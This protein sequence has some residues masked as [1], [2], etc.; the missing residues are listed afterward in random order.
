MK[1]LLRVILG[2]LLGL[3]IVLLLTLILPT[4]QGPDSGDTPRSGF[5]AEDASEQ[6]SP[7]QLE[8]QFLFADLD[9]Q[10]SAVAEG[11]LL[12]EVDSDYAQF[13]A[14]LAG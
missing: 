5:F 7:T 8:N 4:P 14:R 10:Q 9:A 6:F 2:G 11:R 1:N 12:G 3:A 13:F